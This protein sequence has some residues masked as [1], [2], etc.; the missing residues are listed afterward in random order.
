MVSDRLVA[1]RLR[2]VDQVERNRVA[3]LDAARRVFIEKGYAGATLEAIADRA[4]FSKGVVYSQFGSKPDLFFAL[5]ERRIEDRGAENERIV[6][7]DRGTA[8]LVELL[9]AASRDSQEEAGWARLLVEFRALAAREPEL[10]SRYAALHEQTVARLA[11]QLDGL[12]LGR[13]R[14]SL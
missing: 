13:S 8:G 4:G 14:R 9:R 11:S 12:G 7:D 5:L 3:V 6:S 10:N 1:T 2:R